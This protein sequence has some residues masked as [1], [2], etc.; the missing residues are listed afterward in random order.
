MGHGERLPGKHW[1]KEE[2]VR[3]TGPGTHTICRGLVDPVGEAL[4][5]T[6]VC[7]SPAATRK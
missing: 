5:E 3:H 1:F 6:L 2:L 4:R 7:T